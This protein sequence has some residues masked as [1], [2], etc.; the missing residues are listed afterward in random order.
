MDKSWF[1]AML[2]DFVT[3]PA[4]PG[5]CPPE[6]ELLRYIQARLDGRALDPELQ[7]IAR[8]AT[9]CPACRHEIEVAIDALSIQDVP[10]LPRPIRPLDDDFLARLA[11]PDGAAIAPRSPWTNEVAARFETLLLR[12][13]RDA[14]GIGR[15]LREMAG[16]LVLEALPLAAGPALAPVG[17]RGSA[18]VYRYEIPELAATITLAPE[19]AERGWTIAGELEPDSAERAGLEGVMVRLLPAVEAGTSA[20]DAV[21]TDELGCFVFEGLEPGEYAVEIPL[22]EEAALVLSGIIVR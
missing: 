22:D 6:G 11:I 19:P 9:R 10:V 12:W 4:D 16:R 1:E 15:P 21:P 2:E 17:V 5:P 20:C 7:A 13:R 8:H 3:H 18:Q 14:A